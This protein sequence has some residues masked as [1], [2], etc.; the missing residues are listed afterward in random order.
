MASSTVLKHVKKYERAIGVFTERRL[1]QVKVS[2]VVAALDDLE[3]SMTTFLHASVSAFAVDV[4]PLL[5]VLRLLLCRG[6]VEQPLA[7]RGVA[8]ARQTAAALDFET[9]CPPL[10]LVHVLTRALYH[11]PPT[12]VV[13]LLELIAELVKRF[14]VVQQHGASVVAAVLPHTSEFGESAAPVRAILDAL[15]ASPHCQLHGVLVRLIATT[16]VLVR[17]ASEALFRRWKPEADFINDTNVSLPFVF[18][19]EPFALDLQQAIIALLRNDDPF[20]SER[21]L[22][23]LSKQASINE[24]VNAV[25]LG[26][27]VSAVF[28]WMSLDLLPMEELALQKRRRLQSQAAIPWLLNACALHF[29]VFTRV[30]MPEPEEYLRVGPEWEGSSTDAKLQDAIELRLLHVRLYQLVRCLEEREMLGAV[31]TVLPHWLEK[32]A[33]RTLLEGEARRMAKQMFEAVTT[34]WRTLHPHEDYDCLMDLLLNQFRPVPPEAFLHTPQD[35]SWRDVQAGRLEGIVRGLQWLR[36]L[37]DVGVTVPVHVLLQLLSSRNAVFVSIEV[38][39]VVLSHVRSRRLQFED[40]DRI[41]VVVSSLHADADRRM[42]NGDSAR[43]FATFVSLACELFCI[44][45]GCD[46]ALAN[47]YLDNGAAPAP[48]I[49][50]ET[51]LAATAPRVGLDLE[52]PFLIRLL[53]LL[54]HSETNP[55]FRAFPAEDAGALFLDGE[56]RRARDRRRYAST[57]PA[58]DAEADSAADDA[59]RAALRVLDFDVLVTL[60]ALEALHEIMFAENYVIERDLLMQQ[61]QPFLVPRLWLMCDAEYRAGIAP[62]FD[63]VAYALRLDSQFIEAAVGRSVESPDPTIR[64]NAVNRSASLLARSSVARKTHKFFGMLFVYLIRATTDP[65]EVVRVLAHTHVRALTRTETYSHLESV[66]LLFEEGDVEIRTSIAK[67]MLVFNQAYPLYTALPWTTIRAQLKPFDTASLP[68]DVVKASNHVESLKAYN[69]KAMLVS[70]GLQMVRTQPIDPSDPVACDQVRSLLVAVSDLIASDE[71]AVFENNLI[72]TSVVASLSL[73]FDVAAP[74]A[75]LVIPHALNAARTSLAREGLL[76]HSARQWL[77]LFQLLLAEFDVTGAPEA[78][79]D[80]LLLVTKFV[81]ELGLLEKLRVICASA[82]ELATMRV[83]HI[84]SSLLD[85]LVPALLVVY[86]E[87]KTER[88]VALNKAVHSTLAQLFSHFPDVITN[89]MS[90]P[91]A[92]LHLPTEAFWRHFVAVLE[93]EACTVPLG[94]TFVVA[95]RRGVADDDS[96]LLRN[97]VEFADRVLAA[98]DVDSEF[99][100][101]AVTA[102]RTV[103]Q[104]VHPRGVLAFAHAVTKNSI[105]WKAPSKVK[106]S[107]LRASC[108]STE[109]VDAAVLLLRSCSAAFSKDPSTW[110]QPIVEAVVEALRSKQ[111]NYD[112]LLAFTKHAKADMHNRISNE[113]GE[114][115]FLSQASKSFIGELVSFLSNANNSTDMVPIKSAVAEFVA[116]HCIHNAEQW[117][118]VLRQDEKDTRRRGVLTALMYVEMALVDIFLQPDQTEGALPDCDVLYNTLVGALLDAK[119]MSPMLVAAVQAF[120]MYIERVAIPRTSNPSLSAAYWPM[121]WAHIH[122]WVTSQTKDDLAL[123]F[124]V[125]RVVLF[126]LHLG[127]RVAVQLSPLWLS[128]CDFVDRRLHR[129]SEPSDSIHELILEIRQLTRSPSKALPADV[130]RD[131]IMESVAAMGSAGATS[132]RLSVISGSSAGMRG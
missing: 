32:L 14:P 123:C 70:L 65:N 86:N 36:L 98:R 13:P 16:P 125:L 81:T 38:L 43:S 60:S 39:K 100:Q 101:D 8:L 78:V 15:D 108:V 107:L 55:P 126:V 17:A 24:H 129:G 88:K 122:D 61:L 105:A 80:T 41:V 76:P 118:I 106:V 127:A 66:S 26:Q 132:D 47:R 128:F 53:H 50:T 87:A 64:Q 5:D 35:R 42:S 124:S 52:T 90:R 102:C 111:P 27:C 23:L 31:L 3:S 83:P 56:R 115:N 75:P 93:S 117:R 119:Q 92:S 112:V 113:V 99:L 6:G 40:I 22:L 73:L 103:K 68:A 37:D 109:G 54:A 49:F 67:Q 25:Q 74:V 89:L 82:L 57:D 12:Q 77:Q 20:L 91:L 46:A 116:L 51:T 7:L 18:G 104:E 28:S 110:T 114:R 19:T 59:R 84:V 72:D 62:L 121:M 97:L 95:L 69:L 94:P 85:A 44:A 10:E 130:L 71:D 58:L 48:E 30:L 33:Q 4:L 11:V 9:T 29:D 120:T 45:C 63:L 96:V 2:R 1:E 79:T 131:M 34:A 21:G